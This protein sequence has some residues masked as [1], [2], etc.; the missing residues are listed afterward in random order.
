MMLT[1]AL[2]ALFTFA[3]SSLAASQIALFSDG[4]CQNSL[5]GLEGPNGY[6]NGTCTDIRRSGEYGSFQ[7]VGLDPGC[8]VTIYVEDTTTTMCGGYQE[9]IQMVDCYNSTFVYYSFD[10]CDP[11]GARTSS[12]PLPSSTSSPKASTGVIVGG[13]VGGVLGFGIILGLVICFIRKRRQSQNW[14]DPP[15]HEPPQINE[16]YA[17]ERMELPANMMVYKGA[18]AEVQQPPVELEGYQSPRHG[19]RPVY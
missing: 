16:M 7:V 15:P 19:S 17:R 6:P 18:I 4:N 3:S 14:D 10:F 2:I 12:A 9:E 8:T 11:A 5:R 1:S 13:V